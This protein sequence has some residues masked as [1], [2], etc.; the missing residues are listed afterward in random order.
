MVDQIIESF[1]RL[2]QNG[3]INDSTLDTLLEKSIIAQSDKEYIMRKD[4]E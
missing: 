1:K 3:K 4:G 2:Y